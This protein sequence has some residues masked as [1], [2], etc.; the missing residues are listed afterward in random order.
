MQPAVAVGR[1]EVE[2][3][4]ALAEQPVV[5]V[6]RQFGPVRRVE[7]E[8]VRAERAEVPGG[9]RAGDDA[10]EVEHP[11]ARGGQRSGRAPARRRAADRRRFDQPGRGDRL[12]RRLRP[13]AVLAADGG[14]DPARAGHEV[15]RL[16]R[17]QGRDGRRD[18]LRIITAAKRPQQRR[19]MP[20]IVPVGAHPAVGGAPE[21]RQRREARPGLLAVDPQVGLAPEGRRDVSQ[22]QPRR[23]RPA[24][25]AV[26]AA[27]GVQGRGGQQGGPGAGDGHVFDRQPGRQVT[28]GAADPEHLE[29]GREPGSAPGTVRVA[30]R[31]CPPGPPTPRPASPAIAVPP[32]GSFSQTPARRP[33]RAR[34]RRCRRGISRPRPRHDALRA[35]RCSSAA[36]CRYGSVRPARSSQASRADRS[37]GSSASSRNRAS[38][39]RCR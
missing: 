10:G 5:G 30:L 12:A 17:A 23:R 11:D 3:R 39:G 4:A 7:P 2:Q 16:P 24:G 36:T 18:R 25:P 26:S 14:G 27:L 8:H 9:H 31:R 20:G 35:I 28:R 6:Q 38:L 15:L 22:V 21:S 33:G 34:R 13:P 29:P 1:A 32:R 37:D 19:A